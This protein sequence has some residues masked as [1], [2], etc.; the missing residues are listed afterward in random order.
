MQ[1]FKREN[2][3]TNEEIQDRLRREADAYIERQRANEA[4]R[5][6]SDRFTRTSEAW[7][8]GLCITAALGVM[9]V[10]FWLMQ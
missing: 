9:A 10:L 4:L 7:M 3:M 5:N 6:T 2:G 8:L 1:V